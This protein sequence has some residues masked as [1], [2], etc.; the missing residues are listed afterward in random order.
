MA[1]D[2]HWTLLAA[3]AMIAPMLAVVEDADLLRPPVNVLRLS[4]HPRG[5]AP[6]IINLAEW[7]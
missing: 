4:L 7:L 6:A 3:N 1:V 5:L 2:R